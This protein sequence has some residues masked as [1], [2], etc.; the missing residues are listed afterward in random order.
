[1]DYKHITNRSPVIPFLLFCETHDALQ[2]L[3]LIV[4]RI[5]SMLAS[6]L[7]CVYH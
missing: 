4:E 3:N 5:C 6:S 7:H 1:M 2:L